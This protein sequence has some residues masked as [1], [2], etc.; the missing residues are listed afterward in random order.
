MKDYD[1]KG[2][3]SAISD[4]SPSHLA[5][6]SFLV[7]PIVLNYWLEAL[8]K[9]FPTITLCWKIVS[10]I[11]LV[12][13]YIACLIW[14]SVENKKKK[15]L[16]TYKNIVLGRLIAN[17]WKSMS[18]DSAR[19]VLGEEFSD[20][21]FATLIE[22]FPDTLRSARVKDTTHKAKEGE[23]QKYKAGI[24]RYKYEENL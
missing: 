24:G 10:F 14:L 2:V 23:K 12:V 4:A 5:L 7:L 3:I 11:F 8:T 6:V 21:Q 15:Q 13:V 9:F 18:F 1:F 19:K 22:A 20:E 17:N 16:E